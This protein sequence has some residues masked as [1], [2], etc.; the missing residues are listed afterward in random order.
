MSLHRYR[1]YGPTDE[2]IAATMGNEW[3]AG[4]PATPA[5]F[6]LKDLDEEIYLTDLDNAMRPLGFVRDDSSLDEPPSLLRIARERLT[7]DASSIVGTGYDQILSASLTAEADHVLEIEACGSAAVLLATGNV[8]LSIDGSPIIT[9]ALLAILG[10]SPFRLTWYLP[11]SANQY[12]VALEA[13]GGITG[14]VTPQAGCT[15]ILREYDR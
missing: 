3:G 11:T 13:N 9:P 14:S 1:F 6:A 15:L 10:V 12:D 8:R 2:M 5:L 4:N 7:A